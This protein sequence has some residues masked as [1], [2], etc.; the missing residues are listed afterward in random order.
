MKEHLALLGSVGLF[1]GIDISELGPMLSCIGARKKSVGKGRILLLAGDAPRNVGIVISGQVH[2]V[3]ED[4]DG[5]RSLMAVLTSGDIFAEALCCAGVPESPVTVIADTDS[6]VVLLDFERILHTCTNACPFHRKLLENMLKLLAGKN[7]MLQN[8]MEILSMKSIRARVL[9]YIE[10][11]APKQGQEVFIPL[12][13]EELANY[14]CVDRSALS[15][16]LM[17]MK[18]D[19]LIEYRKNRFVMK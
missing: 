15:H 18:K 10:S 9:R 7:L 19:G 5:N 14:L 11:F 3:R 8:H 2:V 1:S 16:E 4:H 12:N 17:K 6:S 13:R